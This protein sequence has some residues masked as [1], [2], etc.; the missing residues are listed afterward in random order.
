MGKK[1]VNKSLVTITKQT[2]ELYI[3]IHCHFASRMQ[4][5]CFDFN[6]EHP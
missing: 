4:K 3:F 2:I 6:L 1:L 5:V